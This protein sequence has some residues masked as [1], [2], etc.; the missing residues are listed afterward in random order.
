[1]LTSILGFPLAVYE[2][3]TR[4]WKYGLG[5]ADI[6]PVDVGPDQ[7]AWLGVC[8]GGLVVV[9]LFAV[10]RKLPRTWW[11]WGAVVS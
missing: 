11:I 9:A 6:W 8:L 2:G 4:E 1:M 7:R 10:V 3:F 5:H